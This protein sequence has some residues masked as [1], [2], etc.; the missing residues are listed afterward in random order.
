MELKE[1]PIERY[2]VR[3]NKFYVKREDLCCDENGPT[4]SKVR[5]LM[6]VL[7]RMKAQG[8]THIGYTETSVSMA[9]WGVACCCELLGLKAVIYDPQYKETPD[10]LAFHRT[11]WAKF[12]PII[13]KVSAGMAKVNFHICKRAL[14]NEFSGEYQ[15]AVMLPLGLSFPETVRAARIEAKS[16]NRE[17]P[18]KFKT[19]IVNVGSGTVAAG[20]AAGF[21]AATIYGIMGRTGNKGMKMEMIRRKGDFR[22]WGF[23]RIDFRI[24][25]PGW[26]YTQKSD[27]RCPFPCHPYYDLKAYAWMVENFKVL[28]GPILFWN[29]GSMPELHEEI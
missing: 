8:F 1:T 13:R 14:I 27:I 25:D 3:G 4:F 15:K 17:Y 9:G 19:V 24:I 5:G 21:P 18:V 2:N 16:V 26:E 29:I 22:T 28:K 10:I 12:K 7:C 20:V 6:V 11:Q 23:N